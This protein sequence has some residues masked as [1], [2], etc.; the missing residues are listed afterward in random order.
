MKRFLIADDHYIVRTGVSILLQEEF[1]N[2]AIDFCSDGNAVTKMMEGGV[3]DLVILDISMPG[4]DS[5]SLLKNI[6]THYPD[7]KI[8]ILSMSPEEIYAKKYLQLGVKGYIN[9]TADSAE[10][11]RAIT[12]IINN[13]RYLSPRM[14]DILT[15]E[16]LEGKKANPFDTLSTRELEVLS[17]LL[18]GKNVSQIAKLL[19]MHTSTAG[20]H[21][22]RIL[23]KL[24]VSNVIELNKIAQVFHSEYGLGNKGQS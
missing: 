16:L 4:L 3:Y 1:L 5:I 19:S 20:T 10:L 23:E 17:H 14:Q 11:R 22:A 9:K 13:K 6:F 18:E 21:K 8:L 7:Q 15:L 12:S 24:G 2:A